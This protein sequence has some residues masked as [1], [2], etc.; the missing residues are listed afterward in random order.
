[1]GFKKFLISAVKSLIILFLAML[2]FSSATVDFPSLIKGVFSDIYAYA[3]PEAQKQAISKLAETCSSLDRGANVVTVNQ[4]CANRSMLD[5]MKENCDNY[6][7]LKRRNIAIEN[8][9]QVIKSCQQIE[10]G[11]IEVACNELE[12]KGTLLPD[13]NNMGTL[14]KDYKDGKI[15]DKEFFFNVIVSAFPSQME[16]PNIAL[17]KYN[18]AIAYLNNNKIIYFFVLPILVLLLYLLI[19]NLKLFLIVLGG[20]AFSIGIIIMLPYIAMITYDKLNFIDTSSVLG[21]IFGE[22]NMFEPKVVIS[23]VILMFLRTYNSFIITLGIVFLG[24]GIAGKVYTAKL[25]RE[26]KKKEVNQKKRKTK[27]P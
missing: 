21:S 2:I 5:E 12:E 14:C 24:I 23:L 20:I 27:K 26:L 17:D 25:K 4:I 7:E 22:V 9:E 1:M 3:S 16:M 13:F 8:E 11:E 19:R 18:K 10:S 6:R 15:D